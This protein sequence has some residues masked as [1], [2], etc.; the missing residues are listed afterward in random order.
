MQAGK[1]PSE[2]ET[3][4]L[5]SVE[6]GKDEK[7]QYLEEQFNLERRKLELE[8]EK[9]ELEKERAEFRQ[10]EELGRIELK[11]KELE[12]T[13]KS[14]ELTHKNELSKINSRS[15]SIQRHYKNFVSLILL[16]S[17]I[18]F[19]YSGENFGPYIMGVGATGIGIEASNLMRNGNTTS[20][21]ENEKSEK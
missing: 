5:A 17:G 6:L 11:L 2:Q 4:I 13:A 12:I 1:V 20:S 21:Q 10:K 7:L 16:G 14:N 8:K 3:Q 18:W 9:F 19:T 15:D